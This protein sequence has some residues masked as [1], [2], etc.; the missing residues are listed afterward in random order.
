MRIGVFG[1]GMVGRAIGARLVELGHDVMMGSRTPDNESATE[2]AAAAGETASHG[3]FADAAAHGELNF[4]CTSGLVSVDALRAAGTENLAGKVLVDVSNALDFAQGR[5]PAVGVSNVDSIAERL[6]REFP[7]AHIVKSLNTVNCEVMVDPSK[8]PGEHDI[9]VCGNDEAAKREVV[10]LLQNFGWPSDHI[11]DLG[12]LTAARGLEMYVALWLRLR[13][14]AGK[15]HFNIR[16][17]R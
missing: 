2:W 6:Q 8:V 5:P 15:S 3:T 7:E 17:V 10:S 13:G 14:V 12:D 1:T 4:N 16:L 11:L 9:F